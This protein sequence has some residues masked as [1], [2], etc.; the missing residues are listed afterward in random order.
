[1]PSIEASDWIILNKLRFDAIVGVLPEEQ[2]RAQP[3]ELEVKVCLN[4]DEAGASGELH[5]SVNYAA[6]AEEVKFLATHGRWRLIESLGTALCRLLLAPPT[7]REERAEVARV[8]VRISKPEILGGL[9]L[10]TISLRRRADWCQLSRESFP[11]RTWVE[12]LEKTPLS[13][14]YRVV[15]EAGTAWQPPPQVALYVV[16]G[17]PRHRGTTVNPG[18]VIA[19]CAGAIENHQ[20]RS[21]TLL[22]C[23]APM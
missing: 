5:H 1:M 17:R 22:A 14:A 7:S 12:T 3:L 21:I 23:G 2:T 10:P 15:I 19:R 4:L 13:A 16:A 20:N 18:E 8:E 9:A 11:T 6:I